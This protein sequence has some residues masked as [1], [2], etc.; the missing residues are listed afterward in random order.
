MHNTLM[1][2]AFWLGHLPS[3]LH[4]RQWRVRGRNSTRRR[5][6]SAIAL[7]SG[8]KA[9]YNSHRMAVLQLQQPLLRATVPG[10]SRP[11][12]VCP[13]RR[14]RQQHVARAVGKGP[15]DGQRPAEDL[16]LSPAVCPV[17]KDQQPIH[18]L[19]ELQVS[20][21]QLASPATSP[22]ACSCDP[23]ASDLSCFLI[24][25]FYAA[26]V[27]NQ[28][29]LLPQPRTQPSLCSFIQHTWSAK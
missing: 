17:P 3:A 21:C 13:V 27:P 9:R 22:S 11:A 15:G 16:L 20:W 23:D 5:C 10:G 1:F 26:V 12:G 7:H 8:R 24:H 6:G 28:P 29:Q 4:C 19:Q 14:C 2:A 25:Q 18:E